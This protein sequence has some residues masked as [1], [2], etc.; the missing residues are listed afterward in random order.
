M[1][2]VFQNLNT[3]DWFIK[4]YT[5]KCF[6]FQSSVKSPEI[7]LGLSFKNLTELVIV[8]YVTNIINTLYTIHNSLE[9]KCYTDPDLAKLVQY[10]ITTA[11]S[12]T[13]FL[14]KLQGNKSV[15]PT[16]GIPN[17]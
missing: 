1:L 16:M 2:C 13:S 14:E 11:L 6:I 8:L 3:E 7:S 17:T 5:Q 4:L 10:V 12:I 15:A 9:M